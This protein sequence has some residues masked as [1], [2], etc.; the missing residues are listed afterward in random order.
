MCHACKDSARSWLCTQALL[1]VC[2][3]CAQDIQNQR[4]GQGGQDPQL[5]VVPLVKGLA[6]MQLGDRQRAAEEVAAAQQ[7]LDS[8]TAAAGQQQAA[9]GG[10]R[11]QRQ[12]ATCAGDVW[13]GQQ[14]CVGCLLVEQ[15]VSEDSQ[16]RG[17]PLCRL[18][19][20]TST[21]CWT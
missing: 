12:F 19:Q 10:S 16:C 3:Y 17:R 6:L 2:T 15:S 9:G 1:R 7:L 21:V 11:A 8:S 18:F 14:P 20:S 13:T 5:A 4:A